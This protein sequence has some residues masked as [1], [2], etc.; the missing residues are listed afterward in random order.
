MKLGNIINPDF[1]FISRVSSNTSSSSAPFFVVNVYL[2]LFV[3]ISTTSTTNADAFFFH[4]S[5]PIWNTSS[6]T[7]P[8]S[9]NARVHYPCYRVAKTAACRVDFHTLNAS[10][11]QPA[12]LRYPLPPRSLPIS[13]GRSWITPGVDYLKQVGFEKDEFLKWNSH[14]SRCLVVDAEKEWPDSAGDVLW[15]DERDLSKVRMEFLSLEGDENLINRKQ[16]DYLVVT[17]L[18]ITL[19]GFAEY[20]KGFFSINFPHLRNLYLQIETDEEL[21]SKISSDLFEGLPELEQL[22]IKIV[23]RP[24]LQKADNL[25]KKTARDVT[26]HLPNLVQHWEALGNDA[27]LRLLLLDVPEY[28]ISSWK[29]ARMSSLRVAVLVNAI[30]LPGLSVPAGEDV[31]TSGNSGDQGDGAHAVLFHPSTVHVIVVGP[32]NFFHL[33]CLAYKNNEGMI[34]DAVNNTQSGIGNGTT[35][36]Q[37]WYQTHKGT[38]D[39]LGMYNPMVAVNISYLHVGLVMHDYHIPDTCTHMWN[40]LLG[41]KNDTSDIFQSTQLPVPS[42]VG[43]VNGITDK[44]LVCKNVRVTESLVYGLL[45]RSHWGRIFIFDSFLLAPTL[46]VPS[47]VT[48]INL[49]IVPT[50]ASTPGP[51]P[52]GPGVSGELIIPLQC[53][54]ETCASIKV[55]S[56]YPATWNSNSSHYIPFLSVTF[57]NSSIHRSNTLPALAEL[58]FSNVKFE[59]NGPNN[60]FLKMFTSHVFP[61][62]EII[63]FRRVQGMSTFFFL[64]VSDAIGSFYKSNDPCGNTSVLSA[65]NLKQLWFVPSEDEACVPLKIDTRF[66]C[67]NPELQGLYLKHVYIHR[68]VTGAFSSIP[69]TNLGI[70]RLL[71]EQNCSQTSPRRTVIESGIFGVRSTGVDIFLNQDGSDFFIYNLTKPLYDPSASNIWYSSSFQAPNVHLAEFDAHALGSPA[72]DQKT[73]H[74][75]GLNSSLVLKGNPLKRFALHFSNVFDIPPYL[76]PKSSVVGRKGKVY[77][78]DI[79][80]CDL[81]DVF[82]AEDLI[83]PK[84]IIPHRNLTMYYEAFGDAIHDEYEVPVANLISIKLKLSNNNLTTIRNNSFHNLRYL[85]WLDLG[86]N[87]IVVIEP[88]FV[89]GTTC[90]G[91]GCAIDLSFNNAGEK[92]DELDRSILQQ[93]LKFEHPTLLLNLS[94]NGLMSYPYGLTPLGYIGKIWLKDKYRFMTLDLSGN[95]ITSIEHSLCRNILYNKVGTLPAVLYVNLAKNN[96]SF[97]SE[98]VFD[99]P[100]QFRLMINLNDNPFLSTLPSQ[101]KHLQSIN[102]LSATGTNITSDTLPCVWQNG[103]Q[104]AQLN[105]LNIFS[106]ETMWD[107]CVLFRVRKTNAYLANLNPEK[108]HYMMGETIDFKNGLWQTCRFGGPKFKGG[109]FSFM[110]SLECRINNTNVRFRDFYE[111]HKHVDNICT[112]CLDSPGDYVSETVDYFSFGII[113]ILLLVV[114]IVEVVILFILWNVSPCD[115]ESYIFTFSKGIWYTGMTNNLTYA[116]VADNLPLKHGD[117]CEDPS[118]GTQC[119]H[120]YYYEYSYKYRYMEPRTPSNWSVNSGYIGNSGVQNPNLY[121][122]YSNFEDGRSFQ[123]METTDEEYITLA[124]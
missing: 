104:L 77:T 88:N 46:K 41:I 37:T 35:V 98:D 96:I 53:L 117:L 3:C 61:K 1:I 15:V 28:D 103:H 39:L 93:V 2:F 44:R 92:A 40:L 112:P 11:I 32:P 102:L 21:G 75:P 43:V 59:A 27:S 52:L 100:I 65:P 82:V 14:K 58:A 107:C 6:S 29:L 76:P 95:N 51:L 13:V 7:I 115:G 70:F 85:R 38:A 123:K 91:V 54:L 22:Y 8:S 106:Q 19:R 5:S 55:M 18:W 105:S 62:L 99:C 87:K 94:Y 110:Y 25:S 86:Y 81:E 90:Q 116:L 24:S 78:V 109:V 45:E 101:A 48:H 50:N 69:L 16:F 17:S 60:S 34:H 63:L 74:C 121:A 31:H 26:L 64:P 47:S 67:A 108:F 72:C 33:L 124:N 30:S 10:T 80:G 89:S 42:S 12:I 57:K 83:P 120:A 36:Y 71:R 20:K 111:N 84:P 79:E 4:S 56:Y 113:V 119:F 118:R 66:S 73:G 49:H 68:I 9:I 114:Y 122:S 97:L 23:V